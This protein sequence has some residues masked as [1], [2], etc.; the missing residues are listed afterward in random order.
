MGAFAT[1]FLAV[2]AGADVAAL[3]RDRRAAIAFDRSGTEVLWANAG[4]LACLGDPRTD[5]PVRLPAASPTARRIAAIAGRLPGDGARIERIPL[6]L[7]IVPVQAACQVRRLLVG[8]ERV[9]LAVVV[10]G[11]GAVATDAVAAE[12]YQRLEQRLAHTAAAEPEAAP[13]PPEPRA[14]A[15]AGGA[16][17]DTPGEG[18][19]DAADPAHAGDLLDAAA[20]DAA[21]RHFAA[22]AEPDAGVLPPRPALADEAHDDQPA[23]PVRFPPEPDEEPDLVELHGVPEYPPPDWA[24]PTGAGEAGTASPAGDRP[25]ARESTREERYGRAAHG[26]TIR[27]VFE[28]DAEHGFTFVSP[29]LA[30]AVGPRAAA[31]QGR[32][33]PEIAAA[34]G[35]DP[36]GRVGAALGRRDTFT[37]LTVDWPVD[38]AAVRVPVDLAGMPVFGRDR[39]FRGYRGFGLAKCGAA[40]EAPVH[41]EAAALPVAGLL[42][43]EEI[44]LGLVIVEAETE[45]GAAPVTVEGEDLSEPDAALAAAEDD[46]GEPAAP[47]EAASEEGAA[48][49]TSAV[50]A[51]LDAEA[52]EAERASP[53]GEDEADMGALA[54]LDGAS[55]EEIAA[56]A[57]PEDAAQDAGPAEDT[58]A[59]A[60]SEETGE[61]DAEEAKGEA[62]A[63]AAFEPATEAGDLLSGEAMPTAD[64][65]AP[66]HDIATVEEPP[67]DDQPDWEP[68][69]ADDL[70]EDWP[71]T[72]EMP[73]EPGPDM[74]AFE[75]RQPDEAS[76]EADLATMAALDAAIA[77]SSRDD[78]AP[79]EDP[80][81]PD[82]AP[83][84]DP[85]PDTTETAT[86][87]EGEFDVEWQDPE[88][89]T[90]EVIQSPIVPRSV[91]RA[92]RD[93]EEMSRRSLSRPEREAFLKIAEALGARMEDA[94]A[95]AG[96][97][98][99][100]EIE[101]E[102]EPGAPLAADPL[103]SVAPARG[104]RPRPAETAP[105][106]A[107]V[108][109]RLPV[110][111]AILKDGEAVT[112]NRAFVGLAGYAD[113]DDFEAAG[114]FPAAFAGSALPRDASLPAIRRGDGVEVPVTARLHSIPWQGGV[115]SLLVV[116]ETAAATGRQRAEGAEAR[117]EELEAI[118]D[119]ATD[120]VLVLDPKGTVLG[121][122]RSAEALFGT[123]RSDMIGG[124][125]LNLLA[126][127]SHRA[128][129]D[130]LDGLAR[131]GVASVLND[132]REV[133]GRVPGGGL[134]P[135]FMTIGR[136]S[137]EKFCAV[138]RDITQWKRAEEELTN[139]KR[140][141]ETASSQKSD[142]LAKIS[143]EIRTP[144]NA[145]IGFSE[146][147]MEERFGP[148]GS[149]RYK[150]YLRD[151][152]LSGAHIM[153]LVNDLL[154][155]SKI[156]AGK[157]DLAFEAV[158][159]NE[160]IR[161]CVALMQPQANRERVIIRT[162][163]S[164]SLPNVVADSRSLRQIVLN[165]LSNAIKFNTP[166]GQVIVSTLYE[167]TGEVAI[168]VRD[169]GT[170]MSEEDVAKA[171]EPFRQLHTSR[172][173]RGTGLGLPLTKALV[174]ANRAGFRID[175]AV[176]EG[177]LV[178]VTF[179][180]TRVLAE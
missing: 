92:A 88:R 62:R 34:L 90:G 59:P 15:P 168:R 50:E 16:E 137:S 151:I 31:L 76:D 98:G 126:P 154:D 83:D 123:D 111:V 175:S 14:G 20:R 18:P 54:L 72:L 139:A 157:L 40:F 179:P 38:D 64:A 165:L 134:V 30:E 132:G 143:H 4:G 150:E 39:V 49:E 124:A 95:G 55:A 120:G 42:T 9:V 172:P 103:G 70:G 96:A 21:A 163:L 26:R 67:L 141:A 86:R 112:V 52:R 87:P 28:L 116:Q 152:H 136:I 10:D 44:A 118:L 99:V 24:G 121:A 130:Y 81:A 78:D 107:A 119:T 174:E 68:E 53:V 45:D 102:I 159:A 156:E 57:A 113:H 135:L 1:S 6:P 145:I 160:V 36:L 80:A 51:E 74:E 104:P 48:E 75:P 19:F 146:V 155:L 61:S 89:R 82:A 177:T 109:D 66:P 110:A 128:A 33:W 3:G 17:E 164:S 117:A 35:L 8:G 100:V 60:G 125:V 106:D 170:G 91:P 171:L 158:A 46:A 12:A 138:L 153:S 180:S 41:A 56:A 142:F 47:A 162:S 11:T 85:G 22:L 129:L 25:A 23:D 147:M 149:E 173:G 131:N 71:G 140:S 32:R 178:Q 7:G 94:P 148:V 167:E 127:E 114:G 27:F 65:T 13:A 161:E 144:L 97:I 5:G 37:G 29:D 166:G 79:D 133:I 122:N 77:A 58:A 69:P 101:E 63:D 2:A 115:A 43:P 176:G 169:T 93:E 84:V 105:I 73:P 108:L